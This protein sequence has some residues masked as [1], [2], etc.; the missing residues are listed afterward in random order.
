MLVKQI[1]C[2]ANSRKPYGR[3][4]AGI[5]LIDGKPAGWI[6]PIGARENEGVSEHE[7]QYEDGSDPRVLDIVDVPMIKALPN[8]YQ[9]EN[10]L[11]DANEY[12]VKRGRVDL[13]Y[14]RQ[15]VDAPSALWVNGQKTY[16][17]INDKMPIETAATFDHSLRLIC[18]PKL[19]LCV[20]APGE[21][22]G[23]S[24]RRVQ[25]RFAHHGA[26]Y[27]LW[28]TDPVYER[29]YLTLDDGNYTLGESLLTVS[30]SE[31]LEGV[32]FKLVATIFE[33][34]EGLN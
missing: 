32:C 4:V 27:W 11:L 1:V 21:A 31:P 13:E 22:F 25:A 5:E 34:D 12:W 6:R 20:F 8:A 30:V 24:K 7:R 28:V 14:L 15:L 18:V 26:K 17:G 29:G 10:W 23:N 19:E 9:Q 33:F 3:C 16:N 2:L